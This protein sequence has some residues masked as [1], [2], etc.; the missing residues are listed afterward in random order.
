MENRASFEARLQY[1]MAPH[2]FELVMDAYRL[3]KYGHRN[4]ERD[5]GTRYFEH[6]RRVANILLLWGIYDHEMLIA[7]LLHDIKEDS[8]ILTWSKIKRDFGERVFNLI[9]ALTKKPGQTFEKYMNELKQAEEGAQ[10]L[11]FADRLDNIRDLD[12][13]TKEKA[14]K[15]LRETRQY[16]IPWAKKTRPQ[17]GEILDIV[18]CNMEKKYY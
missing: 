2:L 9:D 18:C 4:Q 11:K 10:I 15:Q 1:K 5:D 17:I 14:K 12:G 13:C 7:A 3:S 8:H 16:F 6:P